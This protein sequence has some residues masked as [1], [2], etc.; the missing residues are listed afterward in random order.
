VNRESLSP[1]NILAHDGGRVGGD[2]SWG[3]AG[4]NIAE[5][6]AIWDSELVVIFTSSALVS[7]L[8]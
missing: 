2:I 3:S 1:T 4:L 6:S 5:G 8:K 7:F